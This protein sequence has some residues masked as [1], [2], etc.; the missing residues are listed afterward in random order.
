MYIMWFDDS[1]LPT[2]TKIA[3]AVAAYTQRFNGV[4]PTVVLAHPEEVVE[5]EGVTVRAASNV[6]R[7][8]YWV[9]VEE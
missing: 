5:V 2:A 1:K 6:R 4:R 7:S 9:G 3:Q 8:N